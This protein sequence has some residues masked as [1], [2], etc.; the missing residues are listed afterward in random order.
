MNETKL[1]K[2]QRLSVGIAQKDIEFHQRLHR[3]TKHSKKKEKHKKSIEFYE[4]VLQLMLEEY[5]WN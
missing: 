3:L 4:G 1:L 2:M 5:G